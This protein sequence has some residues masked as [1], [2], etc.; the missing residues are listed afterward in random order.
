MLATA[1]SHACMID[2]MWSAFL[3]VRASGMR[4]VAQSLDLISLRLGGH[5]RNFN[6]DVLDFLFRRSTVG[7]D[8]RVDVSPVL[9]QQLGCI[10]R[11]RVLE[12]RLRIFTI[13]LFIILE[14]WPLLMGYVRVQHIKPY[15]V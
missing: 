14:P 4:Y 6:T 8:G 7:S 10:M 12:T 5:H 1:A 3:A 15:Q 11:R 2:M 13:P 9:G